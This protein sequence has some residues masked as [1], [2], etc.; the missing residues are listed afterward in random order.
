LRQDAG[1]GVGGNHDAGV[2][3]EFGLTGL[4]SLRVNA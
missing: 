4:P 1:V 2:P 3:E